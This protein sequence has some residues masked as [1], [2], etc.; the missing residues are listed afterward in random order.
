MQSQP[1][2]I[3]SWLCHLIAVQSESSYTTSLC[4][5]FLIS[6]VAA[7]YLTGRLLACV[8]KSCYHHTPHFLVPS[9]DQR[10]DLHALSQQIFTKCHGVPGVWVGLQTAP[11]VKGSSLKPVVLSAAGDGPPSMLEEMLV[12]AELPGR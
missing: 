2:W 11:L 12:W 10:V 6:V 1:T 4:L 3:V 7:S 8:N 9:R 5:S